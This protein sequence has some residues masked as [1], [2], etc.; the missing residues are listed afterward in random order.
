METNNCQEAFRRCE[1]AENYG[2]PLVKIS[3]QG[4]EIV[5]ISDLHLASGRMQDGRYA[6]TENFFADGSL[7]RF[8]HAMLGRLQGKRAILVING[9][10]VDFLRIVELPQ[11]EQDFKDW[12]ALLLEVGII[13]SIQ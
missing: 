1:E 3:A 7:Y 5:V 6:G 13:K 9:D 12:Q 10:V 8:I 2:D 11:G 4:A